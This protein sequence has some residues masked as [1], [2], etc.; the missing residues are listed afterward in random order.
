MCEL[1]N[2]WASESAR[3]KALL[4]TLGMPDEKLT[5]VPNV[6]LRNERDFN[7][8]PAQGGCY[9][10]WTN[11]PVRHSLH[12]QNL[13]AGV[14]NGEI[15]YNGIAKD[16]IQSRVRRHL[17]GGVGDPGWSAISMDILED[18]SEKKTHRKKA[19]DSGRSKVPLVN[20]TPIRS[21]EILLQL[22]LSQQEKDFVRQHENSRFFYFRNSIDVFAPKHAPFRFKVYY[23]AGVDMHYAEY[24]EKEWRRRYGSPRLCSYH[25]GR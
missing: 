12:R 1:L 5:G 4:D 21:R 10:I 14:E 11:E 17:N 25:S 13:S 2:D 16:N 6:L 3:L 19:M 24:I 22:N 15:V 23:V 18:V 9:C 20:N 7:S 8:I